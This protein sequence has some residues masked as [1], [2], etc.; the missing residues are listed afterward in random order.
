MEKATPLPSTKN[1]CITIPVKSKENI[2]LTKTSLKNEGFITEKKSTKLKRS[3]S[4]KKSTDDINEKKTQTIKDSTECKVYLN[5]IE[6]AKPEDNVSESDINKLEKQV[7]EKKRLLENLN[8]AEIYRKL[9]DVDKLQE[10]TVTWKRGCI[11]ALNA[12]LTH[13][14]THADIDMAML[15]NNLRVPKKL[16]TLSQSGDLI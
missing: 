3:L 4:L 10:L 11:S 7:Q 14:Q 6:I 13:L 2:L 5:P 16:I 1:E 9:H 12:L 15:L 8:Q